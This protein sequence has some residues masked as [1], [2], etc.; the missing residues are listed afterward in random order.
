MDPATPPR[1]RSNGSST[2]TARNQ[3]RFSNVNSSN[4]D[5]ILQT[6]N[7]NSSLSIRPPVTP[8]TVQKFKNQPFLQPPNAALNR[9]GN[10]GLK[11]PEIS[12]FIR[13]SSIGLNL[14][15][16]NSRLVKSANNLQAV[17]KVLFPTS[18]SPST[19]PDNLELLPPNTSAS[20]SSFTFSQDRSTSPT[21]KT[22]RTNHDIF[23]SQFQIN[24]EQ[25]QQ[26]LQSQKIQKIVPGTPSDK[27]ITT[28]QDPSE[29]EQMDTDVDSELEDENIIIKNDVSSYNPFMDS[30]V[31]TREERLQRRQK[32]ISENPDIE[33]TITY[34][35]KRD[36]T[37]VTK[38]KLDK[39]QRESYKPRMLFEDEI[40]NDQDK[41]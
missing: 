18:A 4:N 16:D 12:P 29:R 11:S 41:Q 21:P 26:P 27:I 9:R 24:Y 10:T 3:N 7:K 37:K 14:T 15:N 23:D 1:S 39:E 13:R 40:Y 38:I 33:D 22:K 6:P 8:S 25:Q 32:L 19:S 35:N 28:P 30:K 34:I 17:S 2:A 31:P 20:F 5:N 36:K